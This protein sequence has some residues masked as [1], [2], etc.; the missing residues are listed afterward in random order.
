MT[1]RRGWFEVETDSEVLTDER[2][3]DPVD[4]LAGHGV[5]VNWQRE[6]GRLGARFTVEGRTPG[7]AQ[8]RGRLIF[9]A[10]MKKVFGNYIVRMREMHVQ[11]MDELIADNGIRHSPELVGV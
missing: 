5:S 1:E 2:I 10:A 4:E 11:S 9:D 7:A 3:D 8:R 6:R